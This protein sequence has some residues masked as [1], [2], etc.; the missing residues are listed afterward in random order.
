MICRGMLQGLSLRSYAG[1][2]PRQLKVKTV[3]TYVKDS[4][5][6]KVIIVTYPATPLSYL[7]PS[8]LD[9][10]KYLFLSMAYPTY[11]PVGIYQKFLKYLY[12]YSNLSYLPVTIQY[13]LN[14]IGYSTYVEAISYYFYYIV[15][16]VRLLK[17][18]FQWKKFNM[19]G[20][21][22]YYP[23]GTLA[24][25]MFQWKKFNIKC[26]KQIIVPIS[27]TISSS[28]HR[29]HIFNHIIVG[30]LISLNKLSLIHV[31]VAG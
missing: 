27:L 3:D 8:T 21:I 1:D 22:S 16:T 24:Q 11:S 18:M 25:E 14:G 2:I 28:D 23:Q 30:L 17:E 15:S 12:L 7:P 19:K 5:S 13:L 20:P 10:L 6:S 29:P 9:I 31:F 26:H 4:Y